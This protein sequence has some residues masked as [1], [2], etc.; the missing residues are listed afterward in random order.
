MVRVIRRRLATLAICSAFLAA[1][2]WA[3]DA[4][5]TEEPASPEERAA[6]IEAA[7]EANKAEAVGIL[8]E[9]AAFLAAQSSFS[10]EA[11]IGFDVVQVNG[12]KLEFGAT[13]EATVRRPD[14]LRIEATQ[15]DGVRRTLTFDGRKLSIDLPDDGAYVEVEKPG[16]L[17]TAIDYLVD[18]LQTPAPLHEFLKSNFF[19]EA[20]SRIRSGY[21][22]EEVSIGGRRC[23]HVALRADEIDVQLWVEVGERPLPCN[24]IIT[25]KLEEGSPQFRAHFTAWDLSPKTPDS[26]FAYTPP[27]GAEKLSIQTAIEAAREETEVQ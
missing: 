8:A 27:A 26:L 5:E 13:R 16:D 22:V 1:T 25:Y 18:D 23:N 11:E 21:V 19:A 7:I 12:Q 17:D 9:S 24:L 14:R 3:Q 20:E 2:A 4:P 10:F 15:R 6:A